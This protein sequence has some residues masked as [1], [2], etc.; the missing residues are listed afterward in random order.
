VPDFDATDRLRVF[1]PFQGVEPLILAAV[2]FLGCFI[3]RS[4]RISTTFIQEHFGLVSLPAL[5]ISAIFAFLALFAVRMV[6]Y[7]LWPL[8]VITSL[9][10]C[11]FSL[12]PTLLVASYVAATNYRRP[13]YLV[14]YVV[15]AT[16]VAIAPEMV[17]VIAG[18]SGY[19]WT[20]LFTSFDAAALFVWL[21]LIVGLWIAARRQVIEGL[22]K[23]A[24]Q[25]ERKQEAQVREVRA[26]ERA[27][28]AHDMHDVVAHR[29]SLMV[30]HAGALEVSTQDVQ[31]AASAA[32]IRTIGREA[33]AQLRDV[34]G[35]LKSSGQGSLESGFSAELQPQHTLADLETLLDQSRA[36]G[37]AVSRRDE[38]VA[39]TL[40]LLV[41]HAAYRVVREALTNVHKHADQAAT[42]VLVRYLPTALEVIVR[43]EEALRSADP[44]PGSGIGL[45]GLRQ[46]VELLGGKFT[47]GPRLNGGFTVSAQL[48]LTGEPRNTVEGEIL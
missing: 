39:C 41:E 4:H 37:I 25:K 31:A 40:P 19:S 46:R 45:I 36:A 9:A 47:A 24:E 23:Q 38:G 11:L 35:V 6:P 30:L 42:E 33:L 29:V 15:G 28:I 12:W 2:A 16:A 22:H 5:A 20:N 14:G 44:M 21:P 48:P 3:P 27:R 8:F 26:Q 43:N 32:L 34:L 7:R 1:A 18:L 13:K 17:G 10:W